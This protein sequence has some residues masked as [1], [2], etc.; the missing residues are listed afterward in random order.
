MNC[1]RST[2][3]PL[4]VS[5][6]PRSLVRYL[7]ILLSCRCASVSHSHPL[8]SSSFPGVIILSHHSSMVVLHQATLVSLL[9]LVF[10]FLWMD[11]NLYHKIQNTRISDFPASKIPDQ[12][13][14]RPHLFSPFAG[15][16]IKMILLDHGSNYIYVPLADAFEK[17]GCCSCF[18]RVPCCLLKNHSDDLCEF[19]IG[20]IS[21]ILSLLISLHAARTT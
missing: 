20:S 10:Y 7:S 12:S 6:S 2:F 18:C 17:V 9:L 15:F 1:N 4:F 19:I 5:L 14:D 13:D 16:S 21:L 8:T 11:V 3:S